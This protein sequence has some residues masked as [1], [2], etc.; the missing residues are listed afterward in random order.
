M[1]IDKEIGE[2][3]KITEKSYGRVNENGI[4]YIEYEENPVDIDEGAEVS[5]NILI[6]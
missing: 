4:K 1:K 5:I 6:D 3:N 2:T